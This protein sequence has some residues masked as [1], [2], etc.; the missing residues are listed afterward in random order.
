MRISVSLFFLFF[1]I[2]SFAQKPYFQQEVNYKIE[3]TLNDQNHTISGQMEIEYINH[4]PDTL[5]VIYIHLWGNAFQNRRTAFAEQ[6]L[7]NSDTKFYFA[8]EEEL[9][10][11]SNLAFRVNGQQIVMESYEGHPDIAL[12]R[13]PQPLPSGAQITIATPFTLKIPLSFSRLGHVGESYQMTQWYPKPAVY[14]REGWHPMPYLDQGEFYSE[15]GNFDVSIT[16][17]DNYVVGATGVLQ[18]ESEKQFLQQKIT[19]TDAFFAELSSSNNTSYDTTNTTFPPSSPTMKTIRYTAEKVHDFAW[20]ADKRFYVQKDQ[21]ELSSGRI[22]DTWVMFTDFERN[23]WKEAINY[24]NR[25]VKFYSE[26]V[27]DYPYPQATAIQSALSAGAGMEYPM[28]TVIGEAESPKSLDIVITHEIGHN[29]F[30]G[31]LASNERDHAWM[32]EGINSYYEK[33]YTRRYYKEDTE[34]DYLPEYLLRGSGLSLTELAYL[35][36][37]R[38]NLDQAPDTHSEEFTK[39]NYYLGAYEKP[40]IAFNYLEKFAG[41]LNL[42]G[43]MQA[44]YQKWQFKHPQPAD[45]RAVLEKETGMSLGWLFD[46]LIGSNAKQDYEIK[47]LK[48]AD[49]GYRILVKNKSEFAAPFTLDAIVDS[50]VEFSKWYEGFTGEKV[51]EFPFKG[52][53]ELT[54]DAN[55]V[56]LD[57]NRKNNHI[58][59]SGKTIEPLQFRF[60]PGPE[61]DKRTQ[62]YWAPAMGWNDYDKFMLGLALYNSTIPFKKFDFALIPMYSFVTKDVIG[63]ADVHYTFYPK[64]KAIQSVTLGVGGKTFHYNRRFSNDYDLKFARLAPTV[65]VELGKKHTGQFFQTIQWRTLWINQEFPQFSPTFGNYE[66]NEWVDTYIHELSYFGEGRRALDPYSVFAALEQQSYKDDFGRSQHYLKASLEIKHT[67]HY[68]PKKGFDFRIFA[69]G[70]FSNT[71]RDAGNIF[72]GAFNLIS[73][74]YNDYRF[75][76]FYL[77]RSAAEGILSQQITIRDGGFKNVIGTGFSLGRSNNFIVALNVKADLPNGLPFN[78][79]LKPYFDIGYFDNAMPTG[80]DDSFEDQLLWSGGV[81]LEFVKDVIAIYF[82]LVNS[83]NIDDR[84]AERGNYWNRIAFTLDLRKLNPK[85]LLKRV[86]F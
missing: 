9:D 67:F 78:L 27:G 20:F 3:V 18:T 2:F 49:D 76:D 74:G 48:V 26:L 33:R 19:A 64:G 36:Q 80:A 61:N 77:A 35:W 7:R 38:R 6:Q 72:P 8:K 22:V 40:A 50:K 21:I 10:G 4:S 82:P 62:L 60:L 86:E 37:A 79:P 34:D 54:L 17:P 70:F 55:H 13:L 32:D 45:F 5:D 30:Y 42:D 75:D 51:L 59:A 29:W 68:A 71:R 73:Q 41:P 63:L 28:I 43:A 23:L 57:V 15:F 84:Y 24:V 85:E 66:G 39:I 47:G 81:A 12:L 58:T 53:E 52:F 83:K 44:Y 69:G 14:D 11:Y 1:S 31:I 46:G 56:T 16:L 25:S 65:K